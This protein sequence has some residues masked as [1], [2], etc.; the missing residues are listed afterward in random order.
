ML[1]ATLWRFGPSCPPA[2]SGPP[3]R[4]S[5]CLDVMWQ[6]IRHLPPRCSSGCRRGEVNGARHG[7]PL[8]ARGGG[9][10]GAQRPVAVG[11]ELGQLPVDVDGVGAVEVD[12]LVVARPQV[13]QDLLVD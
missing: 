9:C 8:S 13:R 2:S 7:G 10:R 3:D 6:Q 1:A 11:V 5:I 4:Y 12:V